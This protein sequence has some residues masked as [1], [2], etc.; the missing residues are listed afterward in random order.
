MPGT[1]VARFVATV[2]LTLV[3]VLAVVWASALLPRPATAGQ[4]VLVVAGL[5]VVVGGAFGLMWRL[6]PAA[7]DRKK[8]A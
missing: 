2:L 6:M 7:T 5:V 8:Q 3:C 4:W 1:I